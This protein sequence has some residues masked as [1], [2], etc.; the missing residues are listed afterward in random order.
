VSLE[1]SLLRL[2]EHRLF[3][4]IEYGLNILSS[5]LLAQ[6]VVVVLSLVAGLLVHITVLLGPIIADIRVLGFAKLIACLH[7]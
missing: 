6:I 7:I 1:P 5:L 4:D 2:G 3:T